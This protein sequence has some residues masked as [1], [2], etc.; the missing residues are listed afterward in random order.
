VTDVPIIDVSGRLP[1][2][3]P[4][5]QAVSVSICGV[6][7]QGVVL[8]G[9]VLGQAAIDAGMWAAQSAAY[10][11]A[12]RGGFARSEVILAGQAQACPLAEDVDVIVALA[13]Q[14]W[15]GDRQ[16]LRPGGVAIC[17]EG[18]GDASAVDGLYLAVP[19]QQIAAAAGQPRSVNLVAVGLL[20]GLFDLVP[21]DLALAAADQHLGHRPGNAIALQAGYAAGIALRSQAG[22]HDLREHSNQAKYKEATT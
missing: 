8:A 6:G 15:S 19:L 4:R 10:T 22:G 2:L 3:D 14:G 17:D 20:G 9:V 11:V 16:R 7:G 1:S 5:K 21:M 13:E 18:I 12:A